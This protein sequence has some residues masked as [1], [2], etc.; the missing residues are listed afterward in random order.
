[1]KNKEPT[2][3]H[4]KIRAVVDAGRKWELDLERVH[5]LSDDYY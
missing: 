1:M 5:G 3:N 2:E 4:L